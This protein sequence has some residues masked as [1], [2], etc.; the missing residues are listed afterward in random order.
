MLIKFYIYKNMTEFYWTINR[1][2]NIFFAPFSHFKVFPSVQNEVLEPQI[3][4]SLTLPVTTFVYQREKKK[5]LLI[6]LYAHQSDIIWL[7]SKPNPLKWILLI[8]Q[9]VFMTLT[10]FPIR[11]FF[12]AFM[13]LLA[14]PFAFI[15]SIGSAEK[16][17][18][19]P[20]SW[21]RK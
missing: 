18:E 8:L 9:I 11:L 20:L 6:V 7:V 2:T 1:I 17:L 19:K 21:W 13:M 4:A 5:G 10:L 14:W 16:Q 15:A 3:K 12:A